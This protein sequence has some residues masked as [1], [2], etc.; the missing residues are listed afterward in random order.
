MHKKLKFV[1]VLIAVCFAV[2]LAVF[3]INTVTHTYSTASQHAGVNNAT[4]TTSYTWTKV[5]DTLY[6]LDVN[7]DKKTD[8]TLT[9]A[10][11]A[12]GND[13]W[14]YTFNVEDNE[15]AYNVYEEMTNNGYIALK[16]GYTSAGSD[17]KS[18]IPQEYGTVDPAAHSYTITNHKNHTASSGTGSLKLT[19][20]VTGTMKDPL[21]KFKFTVTLSASPSTLRNKISGSKVFGDV[22]FVNGVATV[23]LGKDESAE[24]TDI[25]AG[26]TYAITEK[27]VDGYEVASKTHD[28]GTI[29]KDT[30]ASTWSDSEVSEWTNN[31]T[32][33]PPAKRDLTEFAVKKVV[34]GSTKPAD[35]RKYSY[36]VHLENLDPSALYSCQIGD[37]TA[38]EFQADDNGT[39]DVSIMLQDGETAKF[40][41][42]V[43][44][45]YQIAESGKAY[46]ADGKETDDKFTP[47]YEI[48]DANNLNKIASSSG[49][50]EKG[51]DLATQIEN[52][53]AGEDATV[54][55]T[56]KYSS[57][58]NLTLRKFV[59][60]ELGGQVV[61]TDKSSD[62]Y[63]MLSDEFKKTI[64]YA[65]KKEYEVTLTISNLPQGFS[66]D[67]S[68]GKVTADENGEY[69]RTFKLKADGTPVVF[70][71]L[72]SDVKYQVAESK[73]SGMTPSY[74]ITTTDTKGNK[75]SGSHVQSSASGNE[76]KELS[77][78][79]ETLEDGQS[80]IVTFTNY[81]VGP[82]KVPTGIQLMIL[83]AVGAIG[84]AIAIAVGLVRGHKAKREG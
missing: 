3:A 52:V 63:Q 2:P 1:A 28:F 22:P 14:T 56:N 70:N 24:M 36:V 34:T 38:I 82:V 59:S 43:D 40:K 21:Q 41:V 20:R 78:N 17:G 51:K 77:T 62:E 73:K 47:S 5:S 45:T 66:S 67:S 37:N 53:D 76:G 8:V 23:S 32:Y 79:E 7:N 46:D 10:K 19:K 54:T 61:T 31:S 69:S 71:N 15:A 83:P 6:T 26:V 11:D 81:D 68:I 33:T 35:V 42:P 49:S 30:D 25:P 57:T 58:Q 29:V 72:P 13:T 65:A 39:A 75:I 48:A 80:D 16:S 50:A 27:T 12:D 18:A 9:M 60:K 74:E 55:F 64:D 4:S 84:L 44:S